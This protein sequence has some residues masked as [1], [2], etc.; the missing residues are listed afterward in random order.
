MWSTAPGRT[1]AS[2][3]RNLGAKHAIDEYL[4]F[5]DDDDVFQNNYVTDV[6]KLISS[7]DH[8]VGA[9]NTSTKTFVTSDAIITKSNK[10]KHAL[11]GAGM[12]F[13]I[14]RDLFLNLGGFDE[15]LTIDE[16]DADF[17]DPSSTT[18]TSHPFPPLFSA[19]VCYRAVKQLRSIAGWN[20][21]R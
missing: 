4:L 20:D 8:K 9:C 15:A 7:T 21:Y 14:E 17:S 13:W 18:I 5:L 6:L 10:L 2:D 1:G 11:F 12:G 16:E 19:D 3:A